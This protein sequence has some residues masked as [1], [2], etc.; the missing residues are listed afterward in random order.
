MVLI[1]H[2][3]LSTYIYL[4]IWV[5]E[6]KFTGFTS[7]FVL[8]ISTHIISTD[9]NWGVYE[10]RLLPMNGKTPLWFCSVLKG[11]FH[12]KLTFCHVRNA[13]EML[14]YLLPFYSQV[15]CHVIICFIQIHGML[16]WWTWN[17]CYL[18]CGIATKHFTIFSA[19]R[20][21]GARLNNLLECITNYSVFFS[22][23][24]CSNLVRP[25]GTKVV[26][27]NIA[28]TLLLNDSR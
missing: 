13:N 22:S 6:M 18:L 2:R 8:H 9:L 20:F 4:C 5:S 21:L 25:A 16:L 15:Y 7:P 28:T 26:G 3:R 1:L 23:L 14:W 24:L 10:K 12:R 27:I 11:Q 17:K 19:M